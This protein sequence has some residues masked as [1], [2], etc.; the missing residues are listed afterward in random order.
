[1]T[2]EWHLPPPSSASHSVV[3]ANIVPSRAWGRAGGGCTSIHKPPSTMGVQLNQPWCQY[4]RADVATSSQSRHLELPAQEGPSADCL[5]ASQSGYPRHS[6]LG[7]Q[8][9]PARVTWWASK[10]S[11]G[12][13]S[14]SGCPSSSATVTS[15][16]QN[17]QVG[18]SCWWGWCTSWPGCSEHSPY[19]C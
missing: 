1:M 10:T 17:Y 8:S 13:L 7:C 15:P 6:A 3:F 12:L 16:F 11:A 4:P 14:C 5:S 19:F 2:S 9:D 18:T